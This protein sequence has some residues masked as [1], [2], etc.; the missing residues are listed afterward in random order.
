MLE[1]ENPQMIVVSI[2]IVPFTLTSVETMPDL[3]SNE[4]DF[5]QK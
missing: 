1:Y 4:N 5:G 3:R 2:D